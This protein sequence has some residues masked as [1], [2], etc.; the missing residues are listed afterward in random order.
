MS[1]LQL[2]SLIGIFG[3]LFSFGIPDSFSQC[4]EE[5]QVMLPDPVLSNSDSYGQQM[6][7]FE[8]YFLTTST[9]NDEYE[10]DGGK[11]ELFKIS[12]GTWNKLAQLNP[13]EYNLQMFFG[14]RIAIDNNI[15]IIA[16]NTFTSSGLHFDELFIYTK[17]DAEEWSTQIESDRLILRDDLVDN[18]GLIVNEIVIKGDIVGI[19][20]YMAYEDNVAFYRI[21]SDKTLSFIAQ[22]DGPDNGT[23][24]NDGFGIDFDFNDDYIAVSGSEIVG[25][26]RERSV[27]VF[28]RTTVFNGTNSEPIAQLMP[29]NTEQQDFAIQV[30]MDEEY[31]YAANGY[32]HEVTGEYPTEVYVFKQP[33]SGWVD[34]NENAILETGNITH[35]GY[36]PKLKVYGDY[37]FLRR[38]RWDENLYIFKKDVEWT[39]SMPALSLNKAPE[40]TDDTRQFAKGFAVTDNYLITSYQSDFNKYNDKNTEKL[41]SYHAPGNVFENCNEP[42]QEIS[43]T[44]QSAVESKY[45]YNISYN[46]NRMAVG[47]IH[48]NAVGKDIGAVYVYEQ[49]GGGDNY[50][51]IQK[52]TPPDG[53]VGDAFGTAVELSDSILFVASQ[54][55]DSLNSDG[56][57]YNGSIGKVYQYK[58]ESNTWVLQNTIYSPEVSSESEIK[59]FG[60]SISYVDGYVAVGQYYTGSSESNGSVYL[61]KQLQDGSWEYEAK[62]TTADQQGGDMFGQKV[63]LDEDLLIVGTGNVEYGYTDEMRVYIYKKDGDQWESK[64]E[65]AYLLPSSKHRFDRFGFSIDRLNDLIVVGSPGYNYGDTKTFAGRAYV[66]KQPESGW[67]GVINETLILE[68]ESPVD[69]DFFGYS[70]HI[71]QNNILIGAASS[72]NNPYSV[73]H[74]SDI[75]DL[76]PGKIYFF[77]PYSEMDQELE[78]RNERYVQL[79]DNNRYL[80][81]FGFDLEG[82]E[83]RVFVSAIYDN[84][85]TGYRAGAVYELK[86]STYIYRIKEPICQ[87]GESFYLESNRIGG[88][89]KG[90]GI[91]DSLSGLFDPSQVDQYG[92]SLVTYVAGDCEVSSSIYIGTLPE[93]TAQSDATTFVC[94]DE[95][96][97]LYVDYSSS[98]AMV[99]TEWF[100]KDTETD[101]FE[102]FDSDKDTI[103]ISKAGFYRVE[104]SAGLC[105]AISAEFFVKESESDIKLSRQGVEE[106]CSYEEKYL[107]LL[108]SQEVASQKWYFM[109]Y[110]ESSFNEIGMDETVLLDNGG[111]YFSEYYIGECKFAS[112]TLEANVNHV[113]IGFQETGIICDS[114]KTVKLIG[115]PAN[116]VWKGDQVNNEG[117]VDVNNLSNGWHKAVYEV[118]EQHCIFRDEHKFE[119]EL[120][121]K[122]VI[123]TSTSKVCAEQSADIVVTNNTMKADISWYL[124]DSQNSIGKKEDLETNLPGQYY[125]EYSKNGCIAKSNIVILEAQ[126]DSVFVPNVVTKNND[127]YNEEFRIRSSGAT[128]IELTIMNRWGDV[129]YFDNDDQVLW[130]ADDVTSGV[131]Y[132]Q[133][134]YL[135]CDQELE[136]DKGWV[137]VLD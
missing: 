69:E 42:H 60:R 118:Q 126:T 116:G 67:E 55:Y 49:S 104:I 35:A 4:L 9:N 63:L 18:S 101:E 84:N 135:S 44:Y 90:E 29:S 122:P 58:L 91:A 127:G 123:E 47:S 130:R 45:G 7:G 56:S 107:S 59:H 129:L 43:H 20:Y 38:E 113:T 3:I 99:A 108:G 14:R 13:S 22:L 70:V 87:N 71:D 97:E 34:S 21:N 124:M 134:K 103:T 96:T 133:I 26:S 23:Y 31:I 137:H 125:A 50:Q 73:W 112:D 98:T 37:V 40:F 62:M 28:N 64:T 88:Y 53:D 78:N 41:L 65:D 121:E 132:W 72:I 75:E 32:S 6:E 95:N 114:T 110:E 81:A 46:N 39:N 61:F 15:I 74:H 57:Y 52:I 119:V 8:D 27:Y 25:Y 102:Y 105:Q 120:L 30:E 48:D 115:Q 54:Y 111:F 94:K 51:L 85:S 19:S 89:W 79:S 17:D 93:I 109:D 92:W 1:S 24:S 136:T 76:Q 100:F 2:K 117:W 10:F 131:Y 106:V 83:D 80:D 16:G 68:P 82:A 12:G 33:V 11:V 128:D 77:D 86:Y 36:R 5:G 66:F